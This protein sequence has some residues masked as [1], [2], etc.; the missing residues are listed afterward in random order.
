M[1]LIAT[2]PQTC[3]HQPVYFGVININMDEKTVGSVDVWRCAA[4]KQRFCEEKQLGVE[5]IAD[6]VGMP[7]IG[8]D[9][10]WAVLVCNLQKGR[11][12]WRLTKLPQNGQIR[13]ECLGEQVITIDTSDYSVRDGGADAGDDGGGKGRRHWSF[14]VDDHVNTAVE[15]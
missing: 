7:K 4:C 2:D 12:K 3:S 9:E 13:H 15:I 5:A 11:D 14:L 6:T 10:R 1:V 8:P